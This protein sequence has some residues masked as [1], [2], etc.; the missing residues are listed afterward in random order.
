MK[1]AL[2]IA[3]HCLLI[4]LVLMGVAYLMGYRGEDLIYNRSDFSYESME[5]DEECTAIRSDLK[6]LGLEIKTGNQDQTTITYPKVN[7]HKDFD[8]NISLKAGQLDIDERSKSFGFGYSNLFKHVERPKVTIE[9]AKGTTLEDLDL[10][11]DMGECAVHQVESKNTLVNM[12]LGNLE[13][14]SCRFGQSDIHLD[15]GSILLNQLQTLSK[16]KMSLALGDL[17]GSWQLLGENDL[18]LDAGS[19]QLKLQNKDQLS[20]DLKTDLGEI[21]VDGESKGNKYQS[22]AQ[23]DEQ[24]KLHVT[25]NVGDIDLEK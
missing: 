1:R 7:Q 18:Q 15:M 5:L 2:K 22:N 25:A 11:L 21:R 16:S 10:D 14:E 3:K 20:Q 6:L 4:G 8:L 17:T 19:V 12:N 13:I 24:G 9:L 23:G